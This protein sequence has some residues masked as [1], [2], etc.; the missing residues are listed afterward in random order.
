MFFSI[1]VSGLIQFQIM[2]INQGETRFDLE[3]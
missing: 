1:M 3:Y 2:K